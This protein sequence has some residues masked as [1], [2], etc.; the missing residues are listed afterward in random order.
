MRAYLVND[1]MPIVPT[2]P[3]APR[4]G[5]IPGRP[6]RLLAVLALASLLSGCAAL[7]PPPVTP[8]VGAP[9]CTVVNGRRWC[10]LPALRSRPALYHPQY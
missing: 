10:P 3:V 6:P 9:A 1:S 8:T 2:P 7:S 5:A 4:S